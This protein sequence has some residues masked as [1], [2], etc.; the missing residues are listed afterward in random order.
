MAL[1]VVFVPHLPLIWILILSVLSV[2][3]V[4]AGLLLRAPGAWWRAAAMLGALLVLANPAIVEEERKGL[5][6]VAVIVADQTQ[7]QAIGDRSKT[8]DDTVTKLREKLEQQK[9]LDVRVI[10]VTEDRRA[11]RE[12]GTSLF[13]PLADAFA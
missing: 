6:D 2:A 7:S 1:D 13:G 5:P 4:G 9:D 12:G 11:S 8:V 3:L 10:T